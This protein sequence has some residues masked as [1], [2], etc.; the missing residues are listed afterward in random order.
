MTL[1]AFFTLVENH[2]ELK[3]ICIDHNACELT[4]E[5]VPSHVATTI[6][7]GAIETLPWEILEEIMT[8]R[9]E[10][11]VLDHLTRVIGY[12]SKTRNWNQSKLAE[13]ADRQKGNYAIS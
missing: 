5:H 12:Y 4:V 3:G 1:D 7:V 13:L 8:C 6:R 2:P 11:E 9:R 10:P